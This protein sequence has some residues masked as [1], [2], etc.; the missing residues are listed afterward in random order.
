LRRQAGPSVQFFAR[1]GGRAL[2]VTSAAVRIRCVGVKIIVEA[3]NS[4][5]RTVLDSL[6][7]FDEASISRTPSLLILDLSLP[8]RK[9]RT[10][11][12][13]NDPFS[14]LREILTHLT[15]ASKSPALLPALLGI[16]SFDHIDLFEALPPKRRGRTD[17]PDFEFRLAD[18]LVAIES[19]GRAQIA[20]MAIWN[21]NHALSE[22][23]IRLAH[24]RLTCLERRCEEDF[25]F[26][27]P[28]RQAASADDPQPSVDLTDGEFEAL[29][30]TL[31]AHVKAGD[32][33]QVVPSRTFSMPCAD[34][35]AAFERLGADEPSRYRFFHSSD[36]GDLFGASPEP[37]VRLSWQ[38]GGLKIEVTPIAGTCPRG[39]CPD[40][41]D[42]LATELS[43]DEKEV[44]EHL[45]LVDLAR[46]DVARVSRAGTRRVTS[47]MRVEKFAS[48]MHL[49]STI[50]AELDE[51]LDAFDALRACGIAGTLSGAPKLRAIELL[52]S[53]ELTSRGAYGGV[54]AW[55]DGAGAMES[56]VI[57][58]AALVTHGIAYVRA[59]AGIV[60]DSVP[61][62]EA[63]ET[64]HKASAVL[65]AIL[66]A[67]A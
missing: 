27:E 53:Y 30:D 56:A 3:M 34:P 4:G 60:H 42:R 33:F 61:S 7:R 5:A 46:N 10:R 2:I 32:I 9:E 64:R 20:T 49:V 12:A 67:A 14:V 58:R 17:I 19:D 40:H 13:G 8:A 43:L 26:P 1:T 29:V 6:D 28:A 35:L 24:E 37:A 16:L 18:A 15:A 52:R 57:I 31:K 59:G 48:V 50:E 38:E 65:R 55:I 11:A 25:P 45:M 54:I 39:I 21:S 47:L 22:L 51:G 36:W 44:A 62:K 66:S 23:Q 41:E 63:A